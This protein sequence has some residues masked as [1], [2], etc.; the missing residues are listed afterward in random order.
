MPSTP[1]LAPVR[2]ASYARQSVGEEQGLRQQTDDCRLEAVRR[3][4]H[5]VAEYADNDTSATKARG[6]GTAWAAML[7]AFDAGEFDALMVTDVDRL[8][9]SLPDVLE[10]RPPKRDMRIIVVRGSIDTS[11]PSGDFM[12]KQLVLLAEREVAVKTVRAQRYA[13]ERRVAGHPTPGLTPH[14]YRW[15][16]NMERD[17]Q[18][19]RY[20]IVEDE[21]Q[22]VRHVFREFLAGASLGQIARDL[23][24][25]GRRTRKGAR[26]LSSTIRRMLMNPLYAALLPPAQP[27]GEHNLARIVIEE[28]SP[29]AWEPI[30]ERGQVIAT[31]TRLAGTKPNHQGTAR[32][33]LLS[34]LAVCAVCREPVRSARGET[35]P[36]SR[37]DG[38][39]AA[40]SQRYHA[41]RCVRGHF[42]RSG[43]IIDEYVA[44]VCIARLSQPDARALLAPPDDGP[45]IESL[46]AQRI[47]L[48]ARESAIAGLIAAGKMTPQAAEQALEQL[49]AD[50]RTINSEIARVI[51][52]DPLAEL[53]GLD[54][55]RAWWESATLA[56]R[57][58]VVDSLV[59]VAI[60]PVGSGRRVTTLEA[61]AES[62]QLE[63][64]G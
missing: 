32:R 63:W 27:T 19:T 41:Y 44:E 15:V 17:S 12:F 18:G 16:P 5:L 50:L 24:E 57:R 8:T 52:R 6:S 10:V 60:R 51:L 46:N 3:G 1:V 2:V 48:E 25:A 43:D 9:R 53:I 23:N 14:G 13:R 54:D 28:C 30:V 35:H 22:D 4:W 33:W 38:S 39:G 20:A 45:G 21:A 47:E 56:R 64:L 7:R 34:G 55:V 40:A 36:T 26:W 29:G 31:R 49:A 58:A 62:V 61:A 59:V 37:R 42:M 11:D